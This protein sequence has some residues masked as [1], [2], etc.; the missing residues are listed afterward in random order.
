MKLFW[1]ILAGV[2]LAAAVPTATV[3]VTAL[4]GL[5]GAQALGVA[6]AVGLALASVIAVGVARLVSKPLKTF[7]DAAMGIAQGK[8]GVQVDYRAEHELGEL[9]KAFNY[10]SAS[11]EAYD[12]ETQRLMESIENGYLET[13]VA[14][15][16]SIDSKDSY[17]RGHSHRVGELACD[18]GREL[19]LSELQLKQLR[20]G[21]I[22][23]DI[24]KIGIVESI[25]NK[26]SPLT[27]DE[28]QRMRDHSLIG[29]EI[30]RPVSFLK[31]VRAA[32]RNHH[33]WWDGSGYPDALKHEAIPLVA[34]IVTVADTW[35][36]CTTSRPYQKA[37]PEAEA[38]AVL[39][40]LSGRQ[41]DPALFTAFKA[42][43]ARRRASSTLPPGVQLA[44]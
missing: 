27:A 25:L 42:V 35:D 16:N 14:L 1:I 6:A 13:I 5:H 18:I 30:I 44:S 2:L 8:F 33:E 36:A 3:L 17:T 4:S 24:G 10:M 43:L 41:L 23:H 19:R 21:G 34:R 37:L 32:V 7:G 11:V 20:F 12:H 22:L 26:S 39:E 9:A 40:G 28:M 15:A 31:D 29:E 38:L